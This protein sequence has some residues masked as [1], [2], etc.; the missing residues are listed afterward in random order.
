MR[1][2]SMDLSISKTR[3]LEFVFARL[4]NNTSVVYRSLAG[5]SLAITEAGL[6]ARVSWHNFLTQLFQAN[7]HKFFDVHMPQSMHVRL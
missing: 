4:H 1:V 3:C 5:K 2:C 6:F 7:C